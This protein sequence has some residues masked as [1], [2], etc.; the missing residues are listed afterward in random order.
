[1][2]TDAFDHV[3]KVLKPL[4]HDGRSASS[5][6]PRQLGNNDYTA[7]CIW[8]NNFGITS[9]QKSTVMDAVQAVC[10]QQTFNPLMDYFRGIQKQY[11]KDGKLLDDWMY[12]FLGVNASN[13]TERKYVT[14]VSRLMLI[15]A[16][17]RA[18]KPGCKAD[19]VIVLEG[20]PGTGKS[21]ALRVLF[22]M[23]TSEI[24]C[25]TWRLK[26]LVVT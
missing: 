17:A 20:E 18:K 6:I 8:L 11:P 15:Q 5:S 21:T 16:V 1:M 3:K 26:M 23:S 12:R 2:V 9:V 13:E 25:H 19:S 4:P 10:A 24:S 22:R 7:V 14:A